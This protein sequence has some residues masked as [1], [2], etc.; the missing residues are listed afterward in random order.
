MLF[1]DSTIPIIKGKTNSCNCLYIKPLSS[2]DAFPGLDYTNYQ[3]QWG[4]LPLIP[5]RTSLIR[6]EKHNFQITTIPLIEITLT[7]TPNS[8][9]CV[10]QSVS[11]MHKLLPGFSLSLFI[12]YSMVRFFEETLY[13]LLSVQT[14]QEQIT[15]LSY[16]MVRTQ[17]TFLLS[18]HSV[19]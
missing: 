12:T 14:G 1:L 7:P 8:L 19:V 2:A 13:L 9:Q 18:G 5:N 11:C 4:R 10:T 6:S 16:I 15:Q 17:L 3:R